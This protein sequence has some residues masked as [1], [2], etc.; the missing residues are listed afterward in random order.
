MVRFMLQKQATLQFI[1][2][3]YPHIDL[4]YDID[5]LQTFNSGIKD[6][7]P[8]DARVVDVEVKAKTVDDL[9]KELK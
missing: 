2:V 6:N 1:R 7:M 5:E 9:A 8:K 4:G 3:Y